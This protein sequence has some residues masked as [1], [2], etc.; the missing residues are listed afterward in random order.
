MGAVGSQIQPETS[1]RPVSP[2]T[3]LKYSLMGFDVN[4]MYHFSF[5][6]SHCNIINCVFT[7]CVSFTL[8]T[9]Y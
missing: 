1:R 5:V 9:E 3:E 2:M 8:Y 4:I 6:S 7:S